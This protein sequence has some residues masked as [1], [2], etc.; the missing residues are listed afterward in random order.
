MEQKLLELPEGEQSKRTFG[1]R[2]NFDI[3]ACCEDDDFD[4]GRPQ[5]KRSSN[6]MA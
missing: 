2:V 5:C 3:Q 4:D 6:L 1:L